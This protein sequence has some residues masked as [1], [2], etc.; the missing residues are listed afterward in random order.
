MALYQ[1]S[2][3]D[4]HAI[5]G[6]PRD[7]DLNAIKAAYRRLALIK[8]PDKNGNDPQSTAAF[9][10]I[11]QA[12]EALCNRHAPSHPL[13]AANYSAAHM[14]SRV[15]INPLTNYHKNKHG[16]LLVHIEIAHYVARLAHANDK[17]HRDPEYRATVNELH[18]QITKLRQTEA[19]WMIKRNEHR[20][21]AGLK[22]WFEYGAEDNVYACL[23]LHRKRRAK[24]RRTRRQ[25][26]HVQWKVEREQCWSG[27]RK[28][29]CKHNAC[30][31][32]VH[33]KTTI[34]CQGCRTSIDK[35]K[36]VWECPRCS[37]RTCRK[38]IDRQRFPQE[39]GEGEG[40]E[41]GCA[42]EDE[43]M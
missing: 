31:N 38:C 6:V 36:G 29:V 3:K 4:H 15:R 37:I 16:S 32:R 27:E 41:V 5:R 10:E 11:Q 40:D 12:Y 42:R 43:E 23:P 8:R 7:A 25:R 22:K 33:P 9:Q 24:D 28:D 2:I 35:R 13:A 17:L 18:D 26:K 14:T 30:W 19:T 1:S 39:D 21:E 34:A 20:N